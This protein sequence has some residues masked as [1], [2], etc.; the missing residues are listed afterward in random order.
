[1]KKIFS[2]IALL[3]ALF[4]GYATTVSSSYYDGTVTVAEAG[5]LPSGYF[6]KTRNYLPGDI[7]TVSNPE[8]GTSVSVLNLGSLD[9]SSSQVMMISPEAIR[10]L[11]LSDAAFIDVKLGERTGSYED[12]ASGTAILI[13]RGK[14]NTPA[15]KE[16]DKKDEKQDMDKP[17]AT[18]PETEKE[19]DKDDK[20]KDADEDESV[21][22]PA[23]EPVQEPEKEA[24]V[25]P[26]EPER[27]EEDLESV[28]DESLDDIP[29]PEEKETPNEKADEEEIAES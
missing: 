5:Q 13:G 9:K 20:K 22:E 27:V 2:L 16:K 11:G 25:S 6:A 21:Q 23:D 24:A 7:I 17:A 1:M 8:N 10:I 26:K 3:C 12:S 15:E 29:E 14:K 4:S 28:D 19:S 18:A